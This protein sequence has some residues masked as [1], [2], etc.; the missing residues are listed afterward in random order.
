M[1]GIFSHELGGPRAES[2]VVGKLTVVFSAYQMSMAFPAARFGRFV[3]ALERLSDYLSSQN[4]VKIDD[5]QI[6][7]GTAVSGAF[8][9]KVAFFRDR[10]FV[11][12]LADMGPSGFEVD[13]RTDLLI[14]GVGLDAKI[15]YISDDTRIRSVLD[16]IGEAS[17]SLLEEGKLETVSEPMLLDW[18][19]E[20][21]TNFL[22]IL[23]L[24]CNAAVADYDGRSANSGHICRSQRECSYNP[25]VWDA[26]RFWWFTAACLQARPFYWLVSGFTPLAEDLRP[27]PQGDDLFGCDLGASSMTAWIEARIGGLSAAR[28]QEKPFYWLAS[29]FTP[30]AE[31][32]RPVPQGEGLPRSIR[33][34]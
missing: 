25:I 26:N 6:L 20:G 27:I 1:R 28:L 11:V 22:A 7:F 23:D 14:S 21:L 32:L 18:H 24:H 9:L 17:I 16:W 15:V 5:D 3:V 2:F 30:L 13:F 4:Y 12:N 29:G 8:H 33:P 34:S 10:I 31:D 19:I